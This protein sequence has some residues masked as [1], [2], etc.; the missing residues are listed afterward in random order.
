MSSG[1]SR[2]NFPL[3]RFFKNFYCSQTDNELLVPDIKRVE[4]YPDFDKLAHV[5]GDINQ[6]ELC[7]ILCLQ[8]SIQPRLRVSD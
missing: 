5:F 4:N 1:R 6:T 7:M 3:D 2:E 8:Y